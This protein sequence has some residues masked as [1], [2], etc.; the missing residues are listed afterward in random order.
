[1]ASYGYVRVSSNEQNEDRQLR[2]MQH[3]GITDESTFT[4]KQ[5]GKDFLRP[6]YANL[7]KKLVRNDVLYVT[8][9]DR[10]GRNYVDIQSQW[11]F[12]TKVLGVDIVV[13]DMPLLDTRVNKDLMG[14]FIADLTLQILSFL[15]ECE[16]SSIKKRQAEGIEA[17]KARGVRFGR[18]RKVLPPGFDALVKE[19]ET[20][21]ASI[22]EVLSK[23]GIS[24]STFYRHLREIRAARSLAY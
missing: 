3:C 23:G 2:A 6:A 17:A 18:P 10:L 8:S 16:Q 9:I 15:A 22:A 4:D 20:K 11:R 7:V 1:M 14:T 19:W 13:I 5:S 21:G 12:L 24:E